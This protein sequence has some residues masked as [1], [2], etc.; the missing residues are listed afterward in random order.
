VA[1][2]R[3]RRA[4][5]E[6]TDLSRLSGAWYQSFEAVREGQSLGRGPSRR[7][8]FGVVA[9]VFVTL[10][11]LGAAAIAALL[12]VVGQLGPLLLAGA[13]PKFAETNA[14]ARSAEV[15]R[16]YMLPRDPSITPLE[17]GRSFVALQGGA[18]ASL[19]FR[20]LPVESL[21]A[22]PW[23]APLPDGLFA[24]YRHPSV[25]GAPD[26]TVID[27]AARHLKPAELAWLAGVARHP[28]W[29]RFHRFA[30]APAA[31]IFG[32][33]W[34]LPY[35]PDANVMAMPI[36]RFAAL[37]TFAYAGSSRA[38]FYLARGQRDS[39]ELVLREGISFGFQLLDNSNLLMESLIGVVTVGIARAD[40]IRFY[41]L[42]GNPAGPRF[43]AA[44]DSARS[45]LMEEDSSQ[46]IS[47]NPGLNA[48]DPTSVRLTLIRMMHDR[49]NTRGLRMEMLYLL[50]LLPCTNA[51]ELVFGPAP[52]VRGAFTWARANLA[53]YPSDSALL[54]LFYR[55]AE[56]PLPD[57]GAGFA[58]RI[59]SGAADLAGAVLGNRRIPACTRLLLDRG[60]Y[61]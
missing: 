4:R 7:S 53:R 11:V 3:Q 43:Q 32:A 37:K 41:A 28:A 31:D 26:W 8:V 2:P 23:N 30:R 49:R 22:L 27:S 15:S 20:P 61:R 18:P 56:Q 52:D 58:A 48:F 9:A 17:A 59:V 42:T 54:D 45:V 60:G 5:P 6:P 50:G 40:L 1:R 51:Q 36:P 25:T 35:G 29:A 24:G 10:L 14:R 55:R 38:A 19:G 16:P 39:A 57:F 34:A 47:A 13:I 33:E 12:M 44:F 46:S 21:P